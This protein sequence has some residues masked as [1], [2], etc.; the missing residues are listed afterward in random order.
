MRL[1]YS[2]CAGDWLILELTAGGGGIRLW[3]CARLFVW[4]IGRSGMF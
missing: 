1:M 4:V 3:L 2:M